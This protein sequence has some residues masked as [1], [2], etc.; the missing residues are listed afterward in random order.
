MDPQAAWDQL[1][2]A[3][4]AGDWDQIEERRH[5]SCS[6]GSIAAASRRRSSNNPTSTPIGTVPS[7][8][9]AASTPW[10]PS[11]GNG[12]SAMKVRHRSSVRH[13]GNRG[14]K[15]FGSR[16]EFPT[17]PSAGNSLCTKCT[18][19]RRFVAATSK[20]YPNSPALFLER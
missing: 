7:P 14:C 13:R 15:G 3:Y 5:R 19:G 9:P 20:P 12:H 18:N 2:A 8:G 1:L 17:A 4:A 16:A 11:R 6:R 10:K